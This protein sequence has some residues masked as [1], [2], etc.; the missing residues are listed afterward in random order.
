M[1][2]FPFE[3]VRFHVNWQEGKWNQGLKPGGLILTHAFCLE[4][5]E[6]SNS[7]A[8][9]GGPKGQV[10]LLTQKK[11]VQSADFV[12]V[13]PNMSL[14]KLFLRFGTSRNTFRGFDSRGLPSES[15]PRTRGCQPHR[16]QVAKGHRAAFVAFAF[17]I[18][19]QCSRVRP[20]PMKN[21]PR[22]TQL[23][24][25]YKFNVGFNRFPPKNGPITWMKLHRK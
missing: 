8:V 13:E 23:P 6:N 2:H 15:S 3:G 18:S 11:L 20:I 17:R 12:C 7:M 5:K 10:A 14:Q 4:P 1:D 25:E 24:S 16:L 22:R 21:G 19:I 9:I